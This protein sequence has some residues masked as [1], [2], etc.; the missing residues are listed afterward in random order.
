MTNHVL[1]TR[2]L[3]VFPELAELEPETSGALPDAVRFQRLR[4]GGLA[5]YGIGGTE[6]SRPALRAGTQ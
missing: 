2:W 4:R 1:I 6:I 3:N 5:A